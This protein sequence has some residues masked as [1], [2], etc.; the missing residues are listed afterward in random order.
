MAPLDVGGA[1]VGVAVA[2]GSAVAV[3]SVD[4]DGEAGCA[5]PDAP[6]G[7][8][9]SGAAQAAV[10]SMSARATASRF[11]GAI[12]RPPPCGKTAEMAAPADHR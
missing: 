6:A 7:L 8:D 4:A 3:A 12:L 11:M 2:V 1:G 5:L 10:T 9:C